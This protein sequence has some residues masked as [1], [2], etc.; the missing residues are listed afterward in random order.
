M[1]LMGG[2][3]LS[4]TLAPFVSSSVSDQPYL[5][6]Y[7]RSSH[8]KSLA[9]IFAIRITGLGA[10]RTCNFHVDESG[11]DVVS[12]RLRTISLAMTSCHSG[13]HLICTRYQSS[14]G[15][16]ALPDEL[17]GLATESKEAM[18]SCQKNAN[19]N[20]RAGAGFLTTSRL[21]ETVKVR[22]L[23]NTH[24]CAHFKASVYLICC[25]RRPSCRRLRPKIW[26]EL[27]HLTT[28]GLPYEFAEPIPAKSAQSQALG[29]L[30]LAA[31]SYLPLRSFFK[32]NG[33]TPVQWCC[34]RTGAD[35]VQGAWR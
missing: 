17:G 7:Q 14:G 33:G 21:T 23:H 3:H 11:V 26:A 9:S 20:Q 29:Q 32:V 5:A 15:L 1:K 10:C 24:Y 19:S 13:T 12:P 34:T 16:H 35:Q 18:Y 8:S 2:L 31:R 30:L 22:A 4:S 25:V 6:Q 28:L 27:L